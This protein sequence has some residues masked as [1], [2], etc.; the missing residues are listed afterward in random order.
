MAIEASDLKVAD[1]LVLK[2]KVHNF[3]RHVAVVTHVNKQESIY[4][5]IHWRGVGEPYGITETTLP[6]AESLAKRNVEFEC[7]RLHNQDQALKTTQILQQWLSWGVPYDKQRF[8]QAELAI[9]RFFSVSSDLMNNIS[10]KI[11]EEQFAEKL[12]LHRKEMEQLFIENY[13]DI[14]KYA[15]RR[16]ISP[17]RPKMDGEKQTG[18]HC[19]QGILIAFQIPYVQNYVNSVNDQWLSNKYVKT[20][21]SLNDNEPRFENA[22]QALKENF[23]Q[24]EFLASFPLAFKLQAKLCSID[25]FRHAMLCDD[26]NITYIGVLNSLKEAEIH[27]DQEIMAQNCLFFKKQGSLRRDELM[28]KIVIPSIK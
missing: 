24:E 22:K 9:N 12:E 5:I 18:F 17:V 8:A 6:S 13:M 16:D 3:Y 26:K 19:L 14:V 25:T 7:F 21:T 23:N 4:K 10:P 11:K 1:I 20:N 2:D 27:P 15:A 28:H